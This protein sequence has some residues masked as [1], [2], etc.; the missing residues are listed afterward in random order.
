MKQI[1][2]FSASMCHEAITVCIQ[3]MINTLIINITTS[4]AILN[5]SVNPFMYRDNSLGFKIPPC[6]TPFEIVKQIPVDPPH[7]THLLR[8]VPKYRNANN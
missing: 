2:N 8:L 5:S 1:L 7:L 4:I 3:N 6:R